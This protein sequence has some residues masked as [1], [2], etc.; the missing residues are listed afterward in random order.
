MSDSRNF[1]ACGFYLHAYHADSY[2]V[3]TI[4]RIPDECEAFAK[5]L[6][7]AVAFARS[8]P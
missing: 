2:P 6:T 3:T 1:L 8:K 4:A 5:V 7:E